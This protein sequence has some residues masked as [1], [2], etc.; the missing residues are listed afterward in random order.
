MEQSANEIERER[1]CR[2]IERVKTI[3]GSHAR[4][5]VL[6]ECWPREIADAIRILIEGA[7]R[8]EREACAVVADYAAEPSGATERG[9]TLG[10]DPQRRG[11]CLEIA[12]SIRDRRYLTE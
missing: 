1:V 12:K 3:H 11:I 9:E 6:S 8:D 2:F 5:S 4:D 7:V 10:V